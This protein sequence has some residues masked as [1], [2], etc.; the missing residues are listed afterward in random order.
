MHILIFWLDTNKA[1]EFFLFLAIIF[2]TAFSSNC[3]T[4]IWRYSYGAKILYI[5]TASTVDTSL[6]PTFALIEDRITGQN[7]WLDALFVQVKQLG[8][9]HSM[10]RTEAAGRIWPWRAVLKQGRQSAL[11]PMPHKDLNWIQLTIYPKLNA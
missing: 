9:V 7:Y 8:N 3:R 10:D 11:W 6:I 2:S 4:V 5:I 1:L